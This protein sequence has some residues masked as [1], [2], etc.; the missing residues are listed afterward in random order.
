MPQVFIC[1][2]P[3]LRPIFRICHCPQLQ[4]TDAQNPDDTTRN[5]LKDPSQTPDRQLCESSQRAYPCAYT[6]TGRLPH[7]SLVPCAFHIAVRSLPPRTAP[8]RTRMSLNLS[9]AAIKHANRLSRLP[10]GPSDQ[11]PPDPTQ[12]RSP[13]KQPAQAPVIFCRQI[14][15]G[16]SPFRAMGADSPLFPQ[17][18]KDHDLTLRASPS[19]SA[20]PHD[21]RPTPRRLPSP[22][23]SNRAQT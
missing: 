9:P 5:A 19:A 2:E 18:T 10:R 15:S 11:K 21:H 12:R 20:H 13:P 22:R 1:N 14:S 23:R 8:A 16:E 4:I 7:M 17:P 6:G 3:S